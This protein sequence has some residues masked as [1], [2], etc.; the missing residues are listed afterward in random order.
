MNEIYKGLDIR[1]FIVL[2]VVSAFALATF[3]LS[4]VRI[5]AMG[6]GGFFFESITPFPYWIGL[7]TILG[8]LV[9]C[10]P[11]L[12][13]A[14]TRG[15]FVFSSITLITLIRCVFPFTFTNLI[16]YEPDS[17]NYITIVNS[18][19]RSS[20]DLGHSGNYQHDFPLSFL[21]A[22]FFGK[23]GVPTEPFFHFAPFFI[24]AF[25]LV[26]MYFIITEITS[27]PKIGAI[28]VF[29]FSITPLNYWLAVHFCPD[30][31]GSLFFLLALYLVIRL[32][33]S[34]VVKLSYLLPLLVTIFMLILIHHLSTLYFI[35]TMVGLAFFAW[36]F[37]SPFKGKALYFLL[38][39]IYTYTLWFVYGTF[40]YPAFFNIYTY[41][42]QAGSAVTLSMQASLFENVTF[43][44]YPLFIFALVILYLH[45]AIGLRNI[46]KFLKSPTQLLHPNS[47]K[48]ELPVTLQ[49]SLGYAFIFVLFFVGIAIPNI[50]A[51]RVLEVL[52]IGMYPVAATALMKLSASNLSRNKKMLLFVIILI[53]V[54][55][56]IHRYYSQI[57]GRIVGR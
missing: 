54:I 47:I 12:D 35:V 1:I 53:V 48:M 42:S 56:S 57:Q 15:V 52:M 41:F 18:W 11:L 33:K 10:L 13:D 30:L 45:E 28:G 2:V 49:Y 37:K 21:I 46:L 40:M 3:P 39:G 29:L 22:Y 25:E 19:L 32:V 36:Y 24:Y 8:V 17:A 9:Y 51:L 26:L 16:A 43:A 27:K 14:K 31:V 44:I 4:A 55:L 38:I 50:F 6:T 20:L 23:L 7:V 5:S 34:D